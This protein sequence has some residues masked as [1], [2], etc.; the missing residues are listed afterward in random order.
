MIHWLFSCYRHLE[1]S[2]D[3]SS[4]RIFIIVFL[5][6]FFESFKSLNS[7]VEVSHFI[8]VISNKLKE[9]VGVSWCFGWDVNVPSIFRFSVHYVGSNEPFDI[10]LLTFVFLV[11]DS[12]ET[13]FSLLVISSG[14]ASEGVIPVK[15]IISLEI[16]LN[17]VKVNKDVVHLL[18]QKE[19]TSHALTTRNSITLCGWSTDELEKLLSCFQM[20]FR[21]FFLAVHQVRNCFD[22]ILSWICWFKIFYQVKCFFYWVVF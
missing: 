7:V 16:A 17:A 1:D 13:A 22:D 4:K 11:S 21:V 14:C 20:L 18:Q 15:I 10:G 8:W 12:K 3:T 9:V 6:Y 5:I 2:E 19:T